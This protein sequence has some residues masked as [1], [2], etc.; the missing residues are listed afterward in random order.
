M[1]RKF[2]NPD[3]STYVSREREHTLASQYTDLPMVSIDNAAQYVI[4]VNNELLV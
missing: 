2:T 4:D 3:K 1:F